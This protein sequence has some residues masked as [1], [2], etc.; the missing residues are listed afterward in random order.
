MLAEAGAGT[1]AVRRRRPGS[2]VAEP[3]LPLE[4]CP[5]HD[6]RDRD[7]RG[8]SEDEQCGGRD[9]HGSEASAHFCFSLGRA[10]LDGLSFASNGSPDQGP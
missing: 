9:V 10:G 3:G 1:P 7:R 6:V 2:Y 4:P 8:Q 5:R